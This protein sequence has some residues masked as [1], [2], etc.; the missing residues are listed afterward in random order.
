MPAPQ[1]DPPAPPASADPEFPNVRAFLDW[2]LRSRAH[3][4]RVKFLPG[5]SLCE[6]GRCENN[7]SPDNVTMYS[8]YWAQRDPKQFRVRALFK[9]ID[10]NCSDVGGIKPIRDWR[11]AA[12]QKGTCERSD[13]LEVLIEKFEGNLSGTALTVYTEDYLTVD[14]SFAAVVRNE[15]L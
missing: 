4:D 10:L 8:A 12:V 3:I 9:A 15:G 13:G 7:F 2:T 11:Y 6:K 5:A 14:P 1:T